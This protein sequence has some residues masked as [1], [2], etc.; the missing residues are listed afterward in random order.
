MQAL[1]TVA[2]EPFVGGGPGVVL[3]GRSRVGLVLGAAVGARDGELAVRGEVMLSFVLDPFRRRR[4]SPYAAGGIAAVGQ[5]DGSAEYLVATLGLA[6][7]RGR[8]TGWFAEAGVGGGV[9]LAA[10]VTLRRRAP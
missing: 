1:G 10:G 9:R 3:R 6:G 5:R 4:V 8:R 7:M 2:A